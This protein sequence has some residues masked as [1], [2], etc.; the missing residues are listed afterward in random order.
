MNEIG[1][2][3]WAGQQSLMEALCGPGETAEAARAD[4]EGGSA[5]LEE[6]AAACGPEKE[7]ATNQGSDVAPP[8][9]SAAMQTTNQRHYFR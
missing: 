6:A 7:S 1:P 5:A 9:P 3:E 2:Q 8:T 4:R